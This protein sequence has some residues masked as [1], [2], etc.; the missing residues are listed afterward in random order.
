L[1][2]HDIY[3]EVGIDKLPGCV[4]IVGAW[5]HDITITAHKSAAP[6]IANVNRKPGLWPE[7]GQLVFLRNPGAR[8]PVHFC[9]SRS[10]NH[11]ILITHWYV[12][13]MPTGPLVTTHQHFPNVRF[14]QHAHDPSLLTTS[15]AFHY[16]Y[17]RR[18]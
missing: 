16:D 8:F 13:A 5:Q 11:N 9:P 14:E 10:P 3:V 2:H 1:P 12:V 4:G 6:V 17:S 15:R 18:M 7:I